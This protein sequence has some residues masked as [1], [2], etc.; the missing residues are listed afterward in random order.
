MKAKRVVFVRRGQKEFRVYVKT[1]W[2]QTIPDLDF[3]D[4]IEIYTSKDT[5]NKDHVNDREDRI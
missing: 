5:N 4:D 1:D 3:I 2:W